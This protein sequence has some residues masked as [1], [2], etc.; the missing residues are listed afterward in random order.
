MI[1]AQDQMAE[2]D[3]P[4]EIFDRN[5]RR[6]NRLRA[7][8]RCKGEEFFSEFMAEDIVQRLSLI[9]RSFSNCLVVGLLPRK[10]Q[11]FLDSNAISTTHASPAPSK[12]KCESYVQCDEDRLPF[13]DHSFDLVISIGAL[14]TVNDL[15]GALVL[16]KRV[17]VPDG[18]FLAAF[19]GAESLALL[20]STLIAAEEDRVIPHIHPQIDVRTAGDLL[21]RAGFALPVSDSN[22]LNL[23]YSSLDDL[24]KDL[25]NYGGGNVLSDAANVVAKDTY[26]NAQTI[27]SSHL[28]KEGKATETI[29]IIFLCGW[30]P[31]PNQPLPAKRGSGQASLKRA[32]RESK[33]FD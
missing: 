13:A 8:S 1:K 30:S 9:K 19:P 2:T 21:A 24:V 33:S 17:L 23:R 7:N 12:Q 18:L 4:K 29:E 32:L 28:D 22:S 16:I 5:R 25:R 11:A 3:K 14:D 26:L 20:K 31:H 6:S 15:P 10:L 27:F